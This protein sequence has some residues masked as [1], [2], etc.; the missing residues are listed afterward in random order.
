[1]IAAV[2]PA[3][4]LA[5]GQ[6]TRMGRPKPN[7]PL[8]GGTFLTHLVGTL[9]DAGTDDVVIVLGHEMD[10]VLQ[11]FA[12]SGLPARFVENA[13]YA[14]GQL[15]SLLAGLQVVDRPGVIATLVTLVDVAFLSADTVRA[16]VD[17]YFRSRLPVVRPTRGRQHG[18]PLLV[19]R[20]M[21]ERLRRADPAE[22]AKPVV[23]A[24]ATT[25]GDLEIA[26]D[27]AFT[28]IDTL[29]DYERA[30]RLF[31]GD[32]RAGRNRRSP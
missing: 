19:D 13:D 2:V 9:L 6:S 7:L 20:S 15:S 27:G 28:D 14:S 5:A 25:E 31:D 21:F 12:K 26:D 3:I 8:G 4:V 22:G 30:I 11:T 16:V 17:H 29:E 32:A 10:A 1:M 23:R 18:H 24:H